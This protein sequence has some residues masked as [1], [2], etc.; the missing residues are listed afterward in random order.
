[1]EAGREDYSEVCDAQNGWFS[2]DTVLIS[3]LTFFSVNILP[4]DPAL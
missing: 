3:A 4:G 2:G 1:M